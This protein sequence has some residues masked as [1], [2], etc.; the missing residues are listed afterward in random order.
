MSTYISPRREPAARSSL[1]E[2]DYAA[3]GYW[4][5]ESFYGATPEEAEQRRDAGDTAAVEAA[6]QTVLGSQPAIDDALAAGKSFA[7]TT[8]GGP[9]MIH[10]VTCHVLRPHLDRAAVWQEYVEHQLDGDDYLQFLPPTPVLLTADEVHASTRSCRRCLKCSPG[11]YERS[12]RR[13]QNGSEESRQAKGS[14]LHDR[15]V[16]MSLTLPDGS[17]AGRIKNLQVA[18]TTDSGTYYVQLEDVVTLTKTL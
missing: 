11:V 9:L 1:A 17:S 18:V 8:S 3:Y 16:G 5:G 14:S 2:L 13:T 6:R 15:H 4:A 12:R 10:A 7:Y